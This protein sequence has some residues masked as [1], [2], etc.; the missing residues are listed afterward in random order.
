[1]SRGRGFPRVL[2]PVHRVHYNVVLTMAEL[3]DTIHVIQ[4]KR[5]SLNPRYSKSLSPTMDSLLLYDLLL[6]TH[7]SQSSTDQLSGSRIRSTDYPQNLARTQL[8]PVW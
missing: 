7:Q 4:R 8:H 1:M 3:M 2:Q 6:G 5:E